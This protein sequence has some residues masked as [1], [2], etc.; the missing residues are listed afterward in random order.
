MTLGLQYLATRRAVIWAGPVV[1]AETL[2]CATKL[3]PV[4]SQS[5]LSIMSMPLLTEGMLVY[6]DLGN[7][8]HYE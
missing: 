8:E 1:V 6:T 7:R 5:V 4:D 3:F 2:I